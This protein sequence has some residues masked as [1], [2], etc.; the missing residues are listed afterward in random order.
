MKRLALIFLFINIFTVNGLAQTNPVQNS[1]GKMKRGEIEECLKHYFTAGDTANPEELTKAFY[2]GAMMF[3]AD[4]NGEMNFFSQRRWKTVLKETQNPVKA[5]KR[6]IQI[7]DC[8]KEICVAKIVSTFPD[9]TFYDYM[10][11]IKT[12]DSWKIV[13]KVFF[14]AAPKSAP[15]VGLAEDKKQVENLLYTKFKAMDTNDP[16][17]LASAYEP[18]TMSYFEDENQLVGVSIGEWIARFAFDQKNATPIAKAERKIQQIDTAGSVGYAKFTHGFPDRI[19][20][21]YVLLLKTKNR[22][23]IINLL[24]TREN[25]G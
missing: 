23:R 20:T 10:A 13:G 11:I 6:D 19:I 5:L 17:L 4:P 14:R 24:F 15:I 16:D 21:D 25:K 8:T 3:W 7:I 1:L 9:K 22:W 18:R 12:G 2:P